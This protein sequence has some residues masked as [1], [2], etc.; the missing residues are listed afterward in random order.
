MKIPTKILRAV[1]NLSFKMFSSS[2]VAVRCMEAVGVET[3]VPLLYFTKSFIILAYSGL[4]V[5]FSENN[6]FYA[7]TVT[8]IL[9][10][11]NS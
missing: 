2:D 11:N 1:E 3:M 9:S 7:V 6:C 8:F 10:N 5:N 4:M